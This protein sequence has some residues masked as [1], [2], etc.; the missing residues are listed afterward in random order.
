M[1]ATLLAKDGTAMNRAE[2]D[3]RPLAVILL[4]PPGAGK[5]THAGPLSVYLGIPHIS[6]GDLFRENIRSQTPVGQK[7]KGFIDEGKLVPDEVVLQMLFERIARSDCSQGIILDGFPRTVAQAKA[8]DDAIGR[9][10]RLVALNFNIPDD[11]LVERI[12]GRLA[13]KQ[14]GK[15]YHKKNDPPKQEGVC[16]S[17]GGALYQRDDDKE[18]VLRKRLQVYHAETKPLID[19]YAK[20]TG[21]LHDIDANHAKAQVF[22][23]VLE[24]MPH[25]AA[26]AK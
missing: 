6:T 2:P 10:H 3:Q 13:C 15:P 1:I 7:A 18:E 24:A 9:T 20:K 4:G 23:D 14:C 5:G 16:D 8:L 17:C 19:Y 22:H 11:L 12:T 25:V 26:L 21:V